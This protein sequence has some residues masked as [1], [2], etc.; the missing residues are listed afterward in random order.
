MIKYVGLIQMSGGWLPKRPCTETLVVQY[1]EDG[2]G[3]RNT[4]SGPIAEAGVGSEG[5][6][7]WTKVNGRVEKKRSRGS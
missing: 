4:K 6:G 3:R 5:Y 1:G 2:M 7:E